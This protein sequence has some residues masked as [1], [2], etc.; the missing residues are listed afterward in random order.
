MTPISALAKL[1]YLC[2]LLGYNNNNWDQSTIKWLMQTNIAGEIMDVNRLASSG[3]LSLSPGE[4]IM[5]LDGTAILVND[6][7]LGPVLYEIKADG[8]SDGSREKLW[9]PVNPQTGNMPGTLYM[10][11]DSNLVFYDESG[12]V[13]Y[14]SNTARVGVPAPVLILDG[15]N[16]ANGIRLYIYD[17]TNGTII[18]TLYPAT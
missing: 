1:I 2:T 7:E 10:Q 13:L 4:S 3:K 18:K 9:S 12:K 17:Y 5:A 14:A 8:T 15:T 16:Q 11:G 6:F